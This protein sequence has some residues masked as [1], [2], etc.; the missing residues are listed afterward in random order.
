MAYNYLAGLSEGDKE[1]YCQKLNVALIS[2]CP[3]QLP[4][5]SWSTDITKWPPVDYGDVYEYLINTPGKL[6]LLIIFSCIPPLPIQL[7]CRIM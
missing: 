5:G 3:Y 1:R 4:E 7:T 6:T 2:S